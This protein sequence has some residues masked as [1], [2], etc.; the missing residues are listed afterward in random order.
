VSSRPRKP[1]V[2]SAEPRIWTPPLRPLNRKTSAG[3]ECIDFAHEVLGIELMPWQ[4][5]LL[6]HALE[7]NPDGSFRFRTVC[8]LV[9]RQ[10]GK[11]TCIQVLS[12]WRMFVDRAGLVIGTAQNLDVAEEAWMGAVELAQG[13][14]DL[15]SE[16]AAVD[17]TAG[18]KALRL[19]SGERYKVQAA[20]RRGGRGLSGDLVVLDELR[21]HQSWDAWGAVTKTTMARERPQVW[22]L[23]NA[24]DA[25]SVVLAHLYQQGLRDIE[26]GNADTTLGL[27]DWS[28]APACDLNDREQWAQANPALGHRISEDAIRSAQETDPEHVFRT[29]VLCQW[30]DQ[31]RVAVFSPDQLTDL[32]D[33][34]STL[35]DPVAFGIEVS[36]DR[37][38]AAI[39]VAGS[40][41]DGLGHVE[42]VDYRRGTGWVVDRLRELVDR[43]NP[44]TVVVDGG[45]PGGSL[46]A[47]LE[48]ARIGTTLMSARDYAQAC[49]MFYDAVDGKFL[50]HLGQPELLDP[51]LVV[52]RRPLGEAWAWARKSST[53]QDITPVKAA[54]LALWGSRNTTRAEPS[55]YVI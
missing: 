27:F 4:Q 19:T 3:F 1:L 33:E 36:Q 18:K 23:S 49:G 20:S 5:W 54:T 52:Q 45:G 17:R 55:V 7:L 14:P 16:I 13:V 9:A 39:A 26:K 51:L 29:E 35:V 30:V 41:S 34:G 25:E 47:D 11:T 22:G 12:L 42:I 2:G 32:I 43:W 31:A 44:S 15:S 10:N 53:A 28:A 50:R 6:K 8:V 37:S 40:R 24:G 21:E 38:H 48:A 46:L